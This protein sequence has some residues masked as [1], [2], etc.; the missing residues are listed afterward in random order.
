MLT[1]LSTSTHPYITTVVSFLSSIQCKLTKAHIDAAKFVG[2]YL[3]SSISLGINDIHKKSTRLLESYTHIPF[4]EFEPNAFVDANWGPQDTSLSTAKNQR[5]VSLQETKSVCGFIVF[6]HGPPVMR[7]A[8]KEAR[9]SRSSCEAE[10]KAT[11]DCVKAVQY[12]RNVL[13][14]LGSPM[15]T[16]Q[17]TMTIAAQ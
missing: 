12:L 10:I 4:D 3:K 14:Y 16:Y 2:R 9:G 17:F 15:T 5:M 1:W 8:F 6:M 7:K 13:E 11:D